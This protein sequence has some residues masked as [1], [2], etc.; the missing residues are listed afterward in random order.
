MT[1]KR[2]TLIIIDGSSVI[3]RAF[4]AIPLTI[5]NQ[6]G[7]P[8]NAIYGFTQ[9]LKKIIA[10][11]RPDYIGV[12]FDMKGPSFRQ[13]LFTEYKATR[14][15]MPDALQPQIPF[16]KRI[17]A[18]YGIPVMEKAGYEADDIIATLVKRFGNEVKAMIVTGDKDMYQLV[19]ENVVILDYAANKEYGRAEAEAKFGVPPGLLKDLLGLAGDSSDN[20]PG[21]AG[22]GPKTAVK[23]IQE[24]GSIEEIYANIEKVSSEKL[25]EKL[26]A[27][28]AQAE[29]SKE[30]AT[31]HPDVDF[32]TT[33]YDLTSTAPDTDRL[34]PL[35]QEL[36]FKKLLA[37]LTT[38]AAAPAKEPAIIAEVITNLSNLAAE[39][40]R[41]KAAGRFALTL[42]TDA[43]GA[44]GLA[45]CADIERPVF[46]PDGKEAVQELK[47]ILEDDT[48]IKDTDDSKALYVFFKGF[49]VKLSGVGIDTSLASYIINPSGSDHS[50]SALSAQILN[51]TAQDIHQSIHKKA[52]NIKLLTEILTKTLD[53]DGLS[54][55]YK[56]L[57]L[58]TSEVLAD[59]ELAGI[60]VDG[61]ILTELSKEME[62]DLSVM[63]ASIYKAAGAEF[64][65][66][67]PKQLS[68]VLFERLGL[69]PVKKT[70]SG[71][72]T[73][74]EVL[75]QLS[76]KHEVPALILSF[77]QVSKLKSTY[78]DAILELIDPSDGRV[79]TSFN[80]TVT[81]TGRLSSSRPNLQNIPTR[82][83]SALRIREAFVAPKG[84]VF[85]SA[86]YSQIELRIVAHLSQDPALMAAFIKDEDVHTATASE[87][88]GV[89]PGLVTP[90]LRRRAKAI[91]FGIIYGMGAY[92]LSSELGC[93]VK[94]AESYIAGYF[95][96]Y[97]A[98]KAFID[99]TIEETKVNGYTTT[100]FGRRRY[101]PE[102]KSPVEAV[103]RFGSRMAVNT[104]IQGA[105]ADMIK[106]AM[107]PIHKRLAEGTGRSRMLLQIHDEL[108]IE[109]PVEEAASVAELVKD[110][111]EGAIKLLVPIKVNIKQGA[112]WRVVE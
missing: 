104:P 98:V 26:H 65:I 18:A 38:V 5:T 35:L 37:E 29:M 105:A 9:T 84:S 94:E 17:V 79:H 89:L 81:S 76:D 109:T 97:K 74:E 54:G 67:S 43:G 102:L 10:D 30:L 44:T 62:H 58:P 100:L 66:N 85:V 11:W 24:F 22:I 21:V 61:S 48:I 111:M 110:E 49:G 7:M 106:A 107:I 64:N 91:N 57:E 52:I 101:I 2:P 27:N 56:N 32:P 70:K 59:M 53:N 25:R 39:T 87:V 23:L 13:E 46:I 112:N 55:I 47:G 41:L 68:E 88:F 8:T 60:M 42:I 28:K 77:R 63:E 4:H 31:L 19:D 99:R 93:S 82:S 34:I 73:D 108:I 72:S 36:G 1:G 86:D 95:A 14:P 96:H 71:F 12:A 20:I 16:I 3:Y 103:A 51:D 33:L 75:R 69:K 78:V 6:S 45:V 40:E 92:G 80:Q 50:L 90:E 15:P 83:A